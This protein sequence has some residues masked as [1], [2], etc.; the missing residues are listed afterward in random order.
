[1]ELSEC[2]PQFMIFWKL[3]SLKYS[4]TAKKTIFFF[5]FPLI[6]FINHCMEN[7]FL[8]QSFWLC[9]QEEEETGIEVCVNEKS[10]K[11]MYRSLLVQEGKEDYMH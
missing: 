11:M 1:M 5:F 6:G 7:L 10:L 8:D 2:I 4:N 9:S 3:F